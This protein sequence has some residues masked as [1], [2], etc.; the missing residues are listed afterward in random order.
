MMHKYLSHSWKPSVFLSWI[1]CILAKNFWGLRVWSYLVSTSMALYHLI[2]FILCLDSLSIS[3]QEKLL[4]GYCI[5]LNGLCEFSSPHQSI[6]YY[7]AEQACFTGQ[8]GLWSKRKYGYNM[9]LWLRSMR[10]GFYWLA[11][12]SKPL[13]LNVIITLLKKVYCQ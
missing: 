6:L 1:M 2:E 12:H 7:L 10:S 8:S 11:W 5:S 13:L 4:I 9:G 3:K